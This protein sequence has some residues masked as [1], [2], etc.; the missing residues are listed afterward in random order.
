LAPV[1]WH[2]RS[3][4]ADIKEITEKEWKKGEQELWAES[5]ALQQIWQRSS[6]WVTDPVLALPTSHQ[7]AIG[8]RW[9][10]KMRETSVSRNEGKRQ[11][12]QMVE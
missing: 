12:S 7:A 8:W 11:P 9:L 2:A 6:L 4:R 3:R 10:C 1:S 5:V